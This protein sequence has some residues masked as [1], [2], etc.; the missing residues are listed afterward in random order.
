MRTQ[1]F[2]EKKEEKKT[3]FYCPTTW[4]KMKTISSGFQVFK[5]E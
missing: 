2:G 1:F 4:E 5:S 3:G